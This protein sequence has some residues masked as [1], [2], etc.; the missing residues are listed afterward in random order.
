MHTRNLT[1]TANFPD[2][3][4]FENQYPQYGPFARGDGRFL[5]NLIMSIENFIRAQV[6]TEFGYPAV[7]GVAECC[8][9]AVSQNRRI[10]WSNFVKQF[11]GAVVCSLME[12]NH[13][14]KTHK[15]KYVPHKAK[16][17]SKGE[18]YTPVQ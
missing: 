5:Y 18:V 11:I 15:K 3:D 14:Q 2:L 8:F 1:I 4:E 6:F 10:R 16:V 17:F 9:Q 13:Y 12:A 7:T